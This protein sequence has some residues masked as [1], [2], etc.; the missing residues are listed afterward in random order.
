MENIIMSSSR[1][2][3]ASNQGVHPQD[4]WSLRHIQELFPTCRL[5]RDPSAALVLPAATR[6]VMPLSFAAANSQR[7]SVREFLSEACC[8]AFLVVHHGHVVAEHYFN[9]MTARSHHLLYSVSKSFAGMLAGIAVERG[10]L[11]PTSL[12][13]RYLPELDNAAWQGTTVRHLLDM[14]A[15]VGYAE[16]YAD[17][18]T[19]F[20]K[21]AAVVGWGPGPVNDKTP[22][23]LL[24]YARSL[25]R[26]DMENGSSFQYRTVCANVIGMVLE[27]AMGARLATLLEMEIWSVLSVQHDASI[28][29]DRTGFPYVGAGMSACARDLA[30]FGMMMINDG[31]LNG[32]QVVPAAWIADTVKGDKTSKECF[33]KGA[34]GSDAPGWHFRNQIWVANSDPAVML[35]IG[36]HG[37]YVYMDRAHDLVVVM[38]SSQPQPMDPSLDLDTMAVMERIGA[39]VEARPPAA[40]AGTARIEVSVQATARRGKTQFGRAKWQV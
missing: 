4:R 34:Y 1:P 9:G 27:R 25:D 3:T 30:L 17:P 29:V 39:F 24:D 23:S 33:A 7:G 12:L 13:T 11:E 10:Q 16:D 19:D 31:V 15:A 20:W 21:E 6:D 35:T 5:A 32:R 18:E 2:A 26:Q 38:L 14:T 28:V 8:D 37:Q 22:R 36:I 40:P